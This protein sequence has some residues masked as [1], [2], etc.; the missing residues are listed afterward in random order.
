MTNEVEADTIGDWAGHTPEGKEDAPEETYTFTMQQRGSSTV[1]SRVLG[2]QPYI[3]IIPQVDDDT[4]DVFVHIEAGGGAEL[5]DIDGVFTSLG[6]L[7]GQPAAV[8]QIH[9]VTAAAKAEAGLG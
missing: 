4:D 2:L 5:E 8:Q 9:D 6:A 7:L 3:L 1:T